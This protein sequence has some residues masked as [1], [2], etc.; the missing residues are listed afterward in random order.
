MISHNEQIDNSESNK[1]QIKHFI[2]T[3]TDKEDRNQEFIADLF[4]VSQTYVA[5]M[6]KELNISP[7]K[8]PEHYVG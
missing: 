4:D 3:H 5:M 8:K 7:R 2:I 6:F 1:H